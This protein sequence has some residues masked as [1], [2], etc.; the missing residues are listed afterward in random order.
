MLLPAPGMVMTRKIY[1]KWYRP[2]HFAPIVV[3]PCNLLREVFVV[4]SG[5]PL[6]WHRTLV[7]VAS[8]WQAIVSWRIERWGA[9][10][11]V[12]KGNAAWATP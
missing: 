3:V 2:F 12:G 9:M 7:H 5:R 1:Q 11:S 6:H 8:G 4:Y 10:P